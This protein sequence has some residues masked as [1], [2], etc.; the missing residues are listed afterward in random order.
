MS[1][2][3][4]RWM[5]DTAKNVILGHKKLNTWAPLLFFLFIFLYLFKFHCFSSNPPNLGRLQTCGCGRNDFYHFL[6]SS[7]F[8]DLSLSSLLSKCNVTLFLSLFLYFFLSLSLS[9]IILIILLLFSLFLSHNL[10]PSHHH[11]PRPLSLSL[12]LSLS[13]TK[14]SKHS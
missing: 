3:C 12:S 1:H 11:L 5:K 8:P 2:E 13:Q 10:S 7:H 4:K 6:L 14:D 9:L